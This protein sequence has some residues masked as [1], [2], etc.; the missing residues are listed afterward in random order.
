MLPTLSG[1]PIMQSM[2]PDT[3]LPMCRETLRG[4]KITVYLN[5][6]P[7]LVCPNLIVC[8]NSTWAA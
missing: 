3:S 2:R 8:V 5:L 1:C 6:Q 7:T 4:E